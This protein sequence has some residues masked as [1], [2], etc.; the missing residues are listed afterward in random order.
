MLDQISYYVPL[1]I[2]A[3]AENL[4]TRS[5]VSVSPVLILVATSLSII[6]DSIFLQGRFGIGSVVRNRRDLGIEKPR[7][8]SVR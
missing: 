1:E 2:V 6:P 7:N 5:M 3:L 8:H 4:P